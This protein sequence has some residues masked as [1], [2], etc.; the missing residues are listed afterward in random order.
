MAE[1]QDK[2][3]WD[4]LMKKIGNP[5][6]V[7]AIMG[8]LFAESSMNPLCMTGKNKKKYPSE[9]V[10]A[11]MVNNG[12]LSKDEFIHDGI[13][14]G[15]VQWCYYSRKEGLYNYVRNAGLDISSTEVQISYL[16]E[17]MSRHYKTAWA[18]VVWAAEVDEV[19]DIV[20]LKYEKPTTKTD[21]A[22]EKRRKAGRGYYSKYYENNGKQQDQKTE[23][24]KQVVTT[25]PKV[26]VRR[27]NGK[28]YKDVGQIMVEGK[29]YPWIATAENGWHAILFQNEVLWISGEYS[30]V[31]EADT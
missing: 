6:G 30:K 15:L 25:A 12:S 21:A 24:I 2:K 31:E 23:K 3:I 7:A 16:I 13:A 26:F 27:G 19:S 10:Y 17:E 20:M 28:Q 9:K 29:A 1:A 18:A 14:F 11:D 5:Y 4:L 22:K 8:N